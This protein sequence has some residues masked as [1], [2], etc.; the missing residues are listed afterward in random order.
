MKNS[1][2][3]VR[4]ID[5]IFS[6]IQCNFVEVIKSSRSNDNKRDNFS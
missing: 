2:L 3:F 1:I 5:L 6:S 4:V